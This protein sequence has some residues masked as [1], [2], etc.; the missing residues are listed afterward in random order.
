MATLV[1]FIIACYGMPSCSGEYIVVAV[2]ETA[3]C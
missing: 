3:M 1:T 2:I